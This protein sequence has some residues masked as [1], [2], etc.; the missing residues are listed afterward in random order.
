[1][2]VQARHPVINAARNPITK[3][4]IEG[5]FVIKSPDNRSLAILPNINGTTIRNENLADCARDTP[6]SNAVDIVAPD[7]EIPGR[8]AIAWLTPII[9]DLNQF[10]GLAWLN[11]CSETNKRTPVIISIQATRKIFL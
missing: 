10:K 4:D 7:L 1:M 11:F 8:I 3:Y 6:R 2:S 5:I 9:N